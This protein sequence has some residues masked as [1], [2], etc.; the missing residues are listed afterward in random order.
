MISG[1]V[2]RRLCAASKA[3][4][5]VLRRSPFSRFGRLHSSIDQSL[6]PARL[7]EGLM[8]ER[9]AEGD[10]GVVEHGMQARV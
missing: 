3:G 9:D 5:L 4:K 2:F 8:V 7:P 6:S 1:V 10:L